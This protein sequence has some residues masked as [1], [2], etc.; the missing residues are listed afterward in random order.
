MKSLAAQLKTAQEPRI[1]KLNGTQNLQECP[2]FID[3]SEPQW[4]WPG[5]ADPVVSTAFH[6]KIQASTPNR[7]HL[8]AEPS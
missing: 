5:I 6:I 2:R 7:R 8:H 1:P 4:S 3:H